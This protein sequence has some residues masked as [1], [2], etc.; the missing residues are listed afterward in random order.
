MSMFTLQ[1]HILQHI[2]SNVLGRVTSGTIRGD[3][4]FYVFIFFFRWDTLAFSPLKNCIIFPFFRKFID[5]VQ[6]TMH[7]CVAFRGS[8]VG[9]LFQVKRKHSGEKM[10]KQITMRTTASFG[11]HMMRAQ[12]QLYT[13]SIQRI[14]CLFVWF[15]LFAYP[16][17]NDMHNGP[18]QLT[19]NWRI[20]RFVWKF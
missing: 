13:L 16:K 10:K 7:Y 18:T 8:R 3:F 2:A 5:A 1:F 11:S 20:E 4:T 6:C 9:D 15:F 19:S 14:L 17:I 12:V